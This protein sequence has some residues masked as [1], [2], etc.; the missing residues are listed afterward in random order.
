[1]R[2]FSIINLGTS[3]VLISLTGYAAPQ[4]MAQPDVID[5]MMIS[6][7]GGHSVQVSVTNGVKTIV[8]KEADRS[9]KIVESPDDGIEMEVTQQYGPEDADKIKDEHPELYMHLKSFPET[10]G[11][12]K[13]QLTIGVTSE[14]SAYDKDEL[15]EKHPEVFKLYE[16]YTKNQ[17]RMIIRGVPRGIVVEPAFEILDDLD[18]FE[19]KG[20]EEIEKKLEERMEKLRKRSKERLEK[21]RGFE[22]EESEPA[23]PDDDDDNDA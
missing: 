10:V 16:K 7:S 20:M 17:G 9:I 5:R 3:L 12:S 2:P 14:Y 23:D 4:C 19:I 22:L 6:S 13:V 8:A 11:D 18:G 1:M 15:K 21:L